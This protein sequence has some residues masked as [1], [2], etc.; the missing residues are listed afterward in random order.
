MTTTAT[1]WEPC[2]WVKWKAGA[3]STA[4]EQWQG[5]SEIKGAWNTQGEWDCL[6]WLNVETPDQLED[7]VWQELR[8]NDWVETT[9]TG[10]WKKW[11]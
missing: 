8:A 5:R 4:W 11:W 1:A 7:F 9:K 2:I 3:P 10:W 6:L